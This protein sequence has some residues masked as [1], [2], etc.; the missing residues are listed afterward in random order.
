MKSPIVKRERVRWSEG[1]ACIQQKVANKTKCFS[2]IKEISLPLSLVLGVYVSTSYSFLHENIEECIIH[3]LNHLYAVLSMSYTSHM[4]EYKQ[5]LGPRTEIE[6]IIEKEIH[7]A[8]RRSAFAVS[9][10]IIHVTELVWLCRHD[11]IML[12]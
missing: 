3:Y 2:H 7:N 4:R 12:L 8:S 10:S 11:L 5:Y 1:V 9:S 6:R